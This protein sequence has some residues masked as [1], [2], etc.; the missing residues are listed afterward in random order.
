VIRSPVFVPQYLKTICVLVVDRA[1]LKIPTYALFLGPLTTNPNHRHLVGVVSFG[2]VPGCTS[3]DITGFA[4]ILEPDSET[5]PAREKKT[6][7]WIREITQSDTYAPICDVQVSLPTIVLFLFDSK[8]SMIIC[9]TQLIQ[10]MKRI[11]S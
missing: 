8:K 10:S 4:R 11:E 5:L 3:N 6:G 9:K 1:Q 2:P 7:Q